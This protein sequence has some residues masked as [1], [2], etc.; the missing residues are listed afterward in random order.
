MEQN[1]KVRVA[2]LLQ[3][4]KQQKENN[5]LKGKYE[6]FGFYY[7]LGEKMSEPGFKEESADSLLFDFSVGAFPPNLFISK[8]SVGYLKDFYSLFKV[9]YPEILYVL[10]FITWEHI[11][12]LIDR[13]DMNLLKVLFYLEKVIDNDFSVEELSNCI[14]SQKHKGEAKDKW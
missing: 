12:V 1:Y 9:V 8:E 11:K 6:H 14:R 4:Y 3:K 5:L 2:A 7:Q 10:G 13:C